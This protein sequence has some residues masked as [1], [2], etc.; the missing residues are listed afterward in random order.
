M[1]S[2][3]KITEHGATDRIGVNVNLNGELGDILIELGNVHSSL[4]EAI[5]DNVEDLG[6]RYEILEEIEGILKAGYRELKYR[7]IL[8]EAGAT[9]EELDRI[10]RGARRMAETEDED[11]KAAIGRELDRIT[12]GIKERMNAP[13]EDAEAMPAEEQPAE[14][15]ETMPAEEQLAEA[16][17][18]T[19]EEDPDAE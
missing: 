11:E 7:R 3:R 4:Q 6:T 8:H 13:A 1:I 12:D 19:A 10:R 18:G 16:I 5:D 9:E 14:G 2:A 15:T 17:G